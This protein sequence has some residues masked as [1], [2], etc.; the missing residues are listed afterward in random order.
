MLYLCISSHFQS[1][2]G[3]GRC[4]GGGVQGPVEPAGGGRREEGG[5]EK[6]CEK[7]A[8]LIHLISVG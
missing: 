4:G 2:G 1:G 3:W 6:I 5:G 8:Q 7:Y